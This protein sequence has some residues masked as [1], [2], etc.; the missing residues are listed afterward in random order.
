M[1]KPTD[2]VRLLEHLHEHALQQKQAIE[3]LAALTRRILRKVGKMAGELERVQTEVTEISGTIDSAVAL[4]EKLAQLI[5]DNVTD[6]AALNQIADDLDAKGN[7][8]AAA[9]VANDPDTTP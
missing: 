5:R 7:A 2:T 3:E 8:L 9:V 1:A 6:P 4:L